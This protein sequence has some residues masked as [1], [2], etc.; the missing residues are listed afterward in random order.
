MIS[1]KS[2]VYAIQDAIVHASEVLMDKNTAM[3]DKYFVADTAPESN[4]AM[5]PRTVT[6]RYPHLN[7]EPIN[8]SVPLIT[9]APLSMSKLEKATLSANF[10][11]E[12]IGGDLQLHFSG[13]DESGSG[14]FSKKHKTAWGKIEITFS[15][16][17][18][19]EGLQVLVEGYEAIL[20]KQIG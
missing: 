12:V 7:S 6:L 4:G 15:P 2:F 17:E 20:K 3:I 8:V 13:K 14:L 1:F 19:S 10:E 11:M 16:Q 5:I 18:T 9:L